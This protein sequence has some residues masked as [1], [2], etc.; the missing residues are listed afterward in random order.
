ME[1]PESEV[2]KIAQQACHDRSIQWREPYRVKEK[3]R[4]WRVDMP[5]NQRGGNAVIY[6]S[7]KSREAKVRYYPR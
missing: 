1:I 6:V 4:S 2:V 3:W 7:K 5:S